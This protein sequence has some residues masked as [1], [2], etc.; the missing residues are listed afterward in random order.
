[1]I[2]IDHA[3]KS[4]LNRLDINTYIWYT[5]VVQT[6]IFQLDDGEQEL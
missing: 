2:A 6:Y 5:N 4:R 1:M 3:D